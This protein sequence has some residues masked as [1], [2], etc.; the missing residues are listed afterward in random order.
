MVAGF[1]RQA[2]TPFSAAAAALTCKSEKPL[3]VGKDRHPPGK[4]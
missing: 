2:G 4:F 1:A 3:T